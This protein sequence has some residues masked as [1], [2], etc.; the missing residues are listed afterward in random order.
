MFLAIIDIQ[1]VEYVVTPTKKISRS[2]SESNAFLNKYDAE[3]VL[4]DYQICK[5]K[6]L[7]I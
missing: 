5:T 4:R 2:K 3:L 6:I 7:E 1:G